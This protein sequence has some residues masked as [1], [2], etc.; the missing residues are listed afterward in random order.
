MG[1]GILHNRG[2]LFDGKQRIEKKGKK[3]ERK[4][5]TQRDDQW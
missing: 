3:H 1:K 5:D 4:M 2:V